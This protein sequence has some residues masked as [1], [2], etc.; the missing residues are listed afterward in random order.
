MGIE[1]RA[2]QSSRERRAFLT[3]PW[4]VF[5]GDRMWVP[6]IL[7]EQAKSIDP[8]RGV[9][10]THGIAECYLAW[11]GRRIVGTICC[12]EDQEVNA[13]QGRRDAVFGFNHYVPDYAVA[14]ALWQHAERWAQAHALDR[15]VGPFDLDYENSYGVLVEGYDRPPTLMC[16]H[17]PPY[18]REFVA[19]YGFLNQRGQNI[20]LELPLLEFSD[21]QSKLAR[22]HRVA[23]MVRQRGNVR[24][25]GSKMSDW[26]NEIDRVIHLLNRALAVL[27]DFIP[28]SRN[29]LAAAANQLRD[30]IDPDLV[31]FGEIDGEA[32]G[33]LL[34]LP[35][36]N[37]AFIRL[38]GLRYP[39]DW[40][41]APWIARRH[42]QCLCVKSVL[43]LPEFWGRGVDVLMY[44]EMGA[45]ALSKGYRWA[46]LSITSADNPMTPRLA[47][48]LGGRIYKR[49]QVYAKDVK[50]VHNRIEEKTNE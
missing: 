49:W 13:Q 2:V 41:R 46:D 11:Q 21:G 50:A 40:L 9:W 16:G 33:F 18:Y 19:R 22:L 4:S 15:I 45:R 44:E 43:V 29:T 6:P 20:A 38:N 47:G 14:E 34:G 8:E 36:L 35:N 3:F 10:F 24:V 28:W 42:P 23:E 31:L 17:T 30:F 37:E 7:S 26:D 27:P 32:V 1:I 25:R 48:R 12:A 5:H 39:W